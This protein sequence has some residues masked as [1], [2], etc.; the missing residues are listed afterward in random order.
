[1]NSWSRAVR[2]AIR[3]NLEM[4][5]KDYRVGCV[6]YTPGRFEYDVI[7]IPAIPALT[8]VPQS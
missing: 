2:Q 6:W 7:P 4:G 5:W 8:S 3:L 1:M